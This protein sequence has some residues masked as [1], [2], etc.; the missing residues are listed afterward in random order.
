MLQQSLGVTGREGHLKGHHANEG[1][2]VEG[3]K[4]QIRVQKR[5]HESCAESLKMSVFEETGSE[6]KRWPRAAACEEDRGLPWARKKLNMAAT[7]GGET[8]KSTKV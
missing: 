8:G 2:L 3:D 5:G 7:R 6:G 1:I 4:K